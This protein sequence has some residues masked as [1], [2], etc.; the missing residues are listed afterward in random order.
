[1]KSSNGMLWALAGGMAAGVLLRHLTQKRFSFRG[2]TV[3]ITGGSRG[4]G[5]E[6][7]RIFAAEGARL[8][9]CSRNV[10]QVK[11]AVAELGAGGAVDVMGAVCDVTDAKQVD[12]FFN[13]ILARWGRVDVLVN[14]AGV[15]TVSPAD[16][17]TP[18]DYQTSLD[19][20]FWGPL[21]AM[22]AVLPL[23][24]RQQ[25]GRIVN[26]AS[27]GGKI[28]V[29]H[30]VSYSAGKFALVGLSEGLSAEYRREGIIITTVCPGLMA[31]GSPRNA[32]FKGQHQAEYA[33][34]SIAAGLPVLATN[35]TVAARRI[36]EACRR[37]DRQATTSW[38]TAAAI[39]A[40][41]LLPEFTGP[42]LSFTNRMLPAPVGGSG[43]ETHRGAESQSSWSPSW[44]TARNEAAAR[45]NHEFA[46]G[47]R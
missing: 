29:P 7:A 42:A 46:S 44:L 16:C 19:T 35:S 39:R 32:Q 9:I 30:L 20:H 36:V 6:M 3:V 33:W 4:L 40:H 37:G 14:N 8:A 18:E 15:I 13:D 25:S 28:S 22:R 11:E 21:H 24:R 34:F 10:T 31:T 41:G 47:E 1:M 38:L 43:I 45:R 5:L 26:I 17:L 12:E 27:I 2:K 23:M